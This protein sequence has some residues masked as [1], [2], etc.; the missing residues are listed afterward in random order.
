V[1]VPVDGIDLTLLT[2]RLAAH[3]AQTVEDLSADEHDLGEFQRL[4][5]ATKV[6]G[7]GCRLLTEGLFAAG[8]KALADGPRFDCTVTSEL[9]RRQGLDCE[10]SREML[11]TFVPQ[12]ARRLSS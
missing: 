10:P 6:C 4:V 7:R 8:M 11:A 3:P 2:R 12:V 5:A 1:E 9:L